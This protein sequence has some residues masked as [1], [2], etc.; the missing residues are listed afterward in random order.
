MKSIFKNRA[1]HF[2]VCYSMQSE[3]TERKGLT[4]LSF[5]K[6]KKPIGNL[7]FN[8]KVNVTLIG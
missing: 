8:L 7:L 4:G 1:I 5:N 2:Q 6:K 3:L